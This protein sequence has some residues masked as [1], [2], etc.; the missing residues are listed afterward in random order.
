VGLRRGCADVFSRRVVGWSIA[1]HLR[2]ELVVDA[3]EMARWRRKPAGTVVHSD[4]GTQE[5]F[6]WPSQHLDLE[7]QRC[8]SGRGSARIVSIEG[9]SR[10]RAGRR[11][12]G[13]RTVSDWAAIAR[14]ARS[15]DAAADIGVSPAVGTRWFRHAGGV[16]PDLQPTVSGR[17]LSFVEREEIALLRAQEVGVREIAR[18]IGHAP[19]TI[20]R[21]L[22]RN[23]STRSYTLDYR[24]SLAQ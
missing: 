24:A 11:S 12:L 15:E 7:V 8:V 21:E 10:R 20:S 1:D 5:E 14:G 23:T 13:V 4:R 19:S 18:R 16:N 17:Y 3:L 6:N 22:R 9:R 2:S